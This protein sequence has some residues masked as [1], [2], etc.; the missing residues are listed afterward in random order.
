MIIVQN[1]IMQNVN[2]TPRIVCGNISVITTNDTVA[3][4][5]AEIKNKHETATSGVKL[6]DDVS[7]DACFK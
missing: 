3:N 6:Y 2:T 1:S 7:N 5:I 4:P